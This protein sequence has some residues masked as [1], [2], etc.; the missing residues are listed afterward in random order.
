MHV[1]SSK[2][3]GQKLVRIKTELVEGR[4]RGPRLSGDFFLMPSEGV[5]ALER[6]M[7][8]WLVDDLEGLEEALTHAVAKEHLTLAGI[9]PASIVAALKELPGAEDKT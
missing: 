8:G 3:P 1:V 4:L 5:L 6:V 7:D 9:S 2:L